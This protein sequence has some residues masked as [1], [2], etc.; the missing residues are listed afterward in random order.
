MD[1]R[2][3]I[4]KLARYAGCAPKDYICTAHYAGHVE[5]VSVTPG[6]EGSVYPLIPLQGSLLSGVI[7]DSWNDPSLIDEVKMRCRQC[8]ADALKNRDQNDET[9]EYCDRL[10]TNLNRLQ[11]LDGD[12]PATVVTPAP[13][14]E[15]H[16]AVDRAI[17]E[18]FGGN[19]FSERKEEEVLHEELFIV[20]MGPI[21]MPVG[22]SRPDYT[23]KLVFIEVPL[24]FDDRGDSGE[25]IVIAQS[26]NS[27][28]GVKTTCCKSGVEVVRIP[29]EHEG[30]SITILNAYE[31]DNFIKEFIERLDDMDT[32]NYKP[33]ECDLAETA[34]RQLSRMLEQKLLR[35]AKSVDDSLSEFFKA[36]DTLLK[37]FGSVSGPV[38][39][40]ADN[41]ADKPVEDRVCQTEC[42]GCAI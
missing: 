14:K 19:I 23:G 35:M 33:L 1:Y 13:N 4:V 30:H 27:L 15:E 5:I 24:E 41:S 6:Q 40:L 2:G 36:T 32:G 31:D 34:S 8:I 21:E 39:S 3:K 37:T 12:Q 25:Y 28:Y 20:S 17:A 11:S 42:A 18:L 22:G 10:H 7:H 9:I 16:T 29:F 38:G 26:D